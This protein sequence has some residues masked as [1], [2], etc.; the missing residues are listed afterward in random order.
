MNEAETLMDETTYLVKIAQK[1]GKK[2]IFMVSYYENEAA[3]DDALN[4]AKTPEEVR[5]IANDLEQ[6][7]A[8]PHRIQKAWTYYLSML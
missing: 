1:I 5:K 6:R 2:E 8:P 7:M 3:V 4:A